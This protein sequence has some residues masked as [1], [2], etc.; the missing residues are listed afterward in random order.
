MFTRVL[1]ASKIIEDFSCIN[2]AL[3]YFGHM[4]TNTFESAEET[5]K[6]EV[7]A[8]GRIPNPMIAISYA[9]LAVRVERLAAEYRLAKSSMRKLIRDNT[10][11]FTFEPDDEAVTFSGPDGIAE[12]ACRGC[13]QPESMHKG[14]RRIC[15]N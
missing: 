3:G 14:K 15:P 13:G 4:K 2:L 7:R 9:E 5:F 6:K 1:C 10:G 8:S 12:C 11:A